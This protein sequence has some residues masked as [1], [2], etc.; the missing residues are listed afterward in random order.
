MLDGAVKTLG[1]RGTDKSPMQQIGR[2]RPLIWKLPTACAI[3][4]ALPDGLG[5]KIGQKKKQMLQH[6]LTHR[7]TKRAGSEPGARRV[8]RITRASGC[9]GEWVTQAIAM[10]FNSS[11]A[12]LLKIFAV[13]I[14]ISQRNEVEGTRCTCV[15][16]RGAWLR[17]AWH[18]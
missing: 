4:L 7:S 15:L 14:I 13:N 8:S 6:S 9:V 10:L 11:I 3:R 17:G 5:E 12:T 2:D 16:W 1:A 18:L